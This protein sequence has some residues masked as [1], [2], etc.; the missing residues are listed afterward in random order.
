MPRS[1]RSRP[2]S[3][4]T[5]RRRLTSVPCAPPRTSCARSKARCACWSCMRRRWSA[6]RCSISPH[7]SPTASC[8]VAS[9]RPAMPCCAR[10]CSCRTTWNACRAATAIFRSYCC[11]CSTTCVRCATNNPWAKRCCS[12]PISIARCPMTC[13]VPM[14]WSPP[15]GCP[16]RRRCWSRSIARSMPG[17][18]TM[19][20]PIPRVCMN[21]CPDCSGSRRTR[22]PVACCGSPVSPPKPSGK[23]H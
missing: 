6:R 17:A 18:G 5:P 3:R 15:R 13:R 8:R 1:S 22:T 14:R 10:P 23:V 19:R 11:R 9:M 2:T 20:R 16:V 12:H 21:R 7:R 4:P